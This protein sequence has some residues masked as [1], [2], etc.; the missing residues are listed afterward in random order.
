MRGR[1]TDLEDLFPFFPGF[2]SMLIR[3]DMRLRRFI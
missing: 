3:G 1:N 2:Y